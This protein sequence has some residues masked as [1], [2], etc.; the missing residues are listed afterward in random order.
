MR[1]IKKEK[2]RRLQNSFLLALTLLICFSA[3]RRE[4]PQLGPAPSAADAEFD[5]TRSATS[6]NTMH[7]S[8]VNQELQAVWDFGNGSTATGTNVTYTFPLRGTYPVMVTVF[9]SG[10]SASSSKNI[11][12]PQDSV[13][14]LREALTGGGSKTWVIDST[15]TAHFGVGPDPIG[16]AGN[17]PEFYAASPNDKS[18]V[19]M[20]DD[21]Y[22][23]YVDGSFDMVTQGEA[24]VHNS[25]ASQFPGSYENKTDYTAPYPD[26]L[27]ETFSLVEDTDT[28]LTLSGDTWLG[29][30][31]GVNTY[32]IL[33]LNDT[34]LWLQ[35]QQDNDDLFWYLRLIPE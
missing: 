28:T 33:T 15:T 29:M 14:P 31:T 1:A 21:R 5:T 2:M 11:V 20:Y 26:Q 30:Y 17:F 3:C 6:P 32:R 12:I 35:Y 23:F 24:Y 27:G 22:I 18:G 7:F 4:D 34:V 13:G 8:T 9:T 25:Y 10:G 16:S 19:G